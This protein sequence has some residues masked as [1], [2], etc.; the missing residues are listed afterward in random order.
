LRARLG[1]WVDP[2]HQGKTWTVLDAILTTVKGA[3]PPGTAVQ[4][5][6]VNENS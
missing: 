3:P 6:T 4:P 1:L 5:L 2:I